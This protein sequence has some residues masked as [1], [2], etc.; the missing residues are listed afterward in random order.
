MDICAF[1]HD[2]LLQQGSIFGPVVDELKVT[3]T[4]F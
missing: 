2:F 3:T 4:V 1:L